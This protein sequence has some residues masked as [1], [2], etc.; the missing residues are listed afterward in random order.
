MSATMIEIKCPR[1]GHT[2]RVDVAALGK[3]DQVIYKDAPR[4]NRVE[5]YRVRCPNCGAYALVDVEAQEE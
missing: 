1:C 2:W 4:R 5:T 3:P